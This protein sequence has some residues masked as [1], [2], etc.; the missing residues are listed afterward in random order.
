[1]RTESVECLN[2]RRTESARGTDRSCVL[3]F[4]FESAVSG[5][6]DKELN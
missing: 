2:G 5:L 3:D 6:G 1:M 4:Q